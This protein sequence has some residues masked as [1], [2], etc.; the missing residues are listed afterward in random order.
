MK[1][2]DYGLIGDTQTAALVSRTGS[3]DWL[4]LPRFDSGSC[5]AALLGEEKHGRW[6]LCP[7]EE[8]AARAVRWRY[9]PDTLVLESEFE[10]ADGGCVR[11]IDCMPP[12]QSYPDVVRLV[13]GVRGRVKMRMRLI[14]RYDYGDIRPWVRKVA[15]P[16]DLELVAGP[17][18]LILRTSVETRGEDFAGVAEFEVAEGERVPFVLSWHPSHEPAPPALDAAHEVAAT[19][20]WW[21][22][23]MGRATGLEGEWSEAIK[24][25]LITLKA[26]S[27]GPSGGIVA[28]PTTSLPE[29]LGGVRN[30]DYRFCW[31]R[32]AAFTLDALL[33]AGYTEEAGAWRDWLL[34]AVAGDPADLQ[35]LYGVLGER[36]LTEFELPDLPGYEGAHPVRVGNAASG[37]F[38][39]DVYGEV[40]DT[41]YRA[42]HAGVDPHP[43]ALD[44][45]VPTKLLQFLET[46]WSQPDESIW[47]VRGPRQHFTYSKV[48]AWVAVDRLIRTA[49]EF[50]LEAD[51]TRW[52]EMR[53][54]IHR[55]ACEKGYNADGQAFTQAYGSAKLDANILRLP[56]VGFLPP[57]DPRVRTTVEAVERELLRDGFVLRYL[58]DDGGAVDGLPGEEGAFLPC[59]F[60]LAD[61]YHLLGRQEDARAVLE[62]LLSFRNDLGLLSEEYD[63]RNQRLVGNFPQAFTHVAL[64]NTAMRLRAK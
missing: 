59:T 44:W 16:G 24:R 55:D 42:R 30:W 62:R 15:E 6:Q 45:S 57:D 4:C 26:L 41:L 61:C 38:Q 51:L 11:L 3:I 46:Y 33:S 47:E 50:K 52:R 35:I 63:W 8:G 9:R 5:F 29:S 7:E 10:T 39:L 27:Y 37:Q 58:T 20:Q 31:V 34:R 21:R 64:V 36:R 48:M 18:A 22:E 28:A 14:V 12:R 53:D 60:W 43:S 17:D 49:E 2:E 13:E 19:E 25:S 32:D 56:L 54:A 23:W 40:V 1:I